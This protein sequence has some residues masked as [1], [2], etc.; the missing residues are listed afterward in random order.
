MIRVG[1]KRSNQPNGK[2]VAFL[3]LVESSVLSA[4]IFNGKAMAHNKALA[5]HRLCAFRKMENIRPCC[6]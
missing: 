2:S 4:L 3:P 1:G 6:L 5:F